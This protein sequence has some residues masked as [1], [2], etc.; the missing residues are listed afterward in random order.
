VR[1]EEYTCCVVDNGLFTS[2]AQ[3][4]TKDFGQ[5]MY[6]S[7]WVCAF[8]TTNMLTIGDG[9]SGV[10]RIDSI[11]EHIDDID[12]FVF[13]DINDGELQ[14]YLES[15]GKRVFGSRRGEE[16]ENM[17]RASKEHLSSLGL[18]VAPYKVVHGLPA[19]RT[20]LKRN[21][22]QYVK[23]SRTRG[24]GETFFA[25]NYMNIEPRLD[26]LQMK[27]GALVNEMEFICEPKIKDACEVAFDGYCID[28]Q[29]PSQACYGLEAKGRAYVGH[30]T[31]YDNM[32]DQITEPNAK[33]APTLK[34]YG[35]RNF[36]AMEARITADGTPWI[37]DPCM[38]FGSPPSEM[39]QV[40]Y[41][42][43]AE[44]F[45]E[46]SA[47]NLV[48][49]VP[50]GEWGAELVLHATWAEENWLEVQSPKDL[51]P[52]VKLR[53]LTIVDGHKYIVPSGTG[54]G[55]VVAVAETQQK[56]IDLCIERADKIEAYT[57]EYAKEAF[58]EI[59]EQA[60][61]MKKYTGVTF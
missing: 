56:A 12:L 58:Q 42:N 21:E 30:F 57:L 10:K 25:K 46:G 54:I 29:F 60:K 17:R 5:V 40:M 1:Y 41:S 3:L 27:V 14:L 34:S 18:H 16:L 43:L 49:P 11:W 15:I 26:T 24:D 23:I 59:D 35:Y 6:A 28:G 9:I 36:F 39:L 53:N 44:I 19:L 8:P 13:P 61:L 33:I 31:D 2:L 4:L 55:A 45:W 22:D 32:P 50:A 48:E 51:E 52:F 7:P 20:F 38:R 47:G 37:I